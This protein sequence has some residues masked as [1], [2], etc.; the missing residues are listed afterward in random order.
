MTETMVHTD[1]NGVAGLLQ[2]ILVAEVTSA[3]RVCQ[4]CGTRAV[5][6]EHRAYCGAGVVL[7]CPACGDVAARISAQDDRHVVELRGVWVFDRA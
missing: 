7:R 6:G 1:A 5:A 2:E 3:R 4:S